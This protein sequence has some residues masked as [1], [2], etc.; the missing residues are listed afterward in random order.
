MNDAALAVALARGPFHR[1]LRAAIEARGLSLQCLQ[2]QLD[3][4]D[5]R[6]GTGTLSYW[7]S[8]QRRPERP[9]SLQAVAALEAILGLPTDALLR[10]LDPR[11]RGEAR[12]VSGIPRPIS[13]LLLDPEPMVTLLHDLRGQAPPL[14]LQVAVDVVTLS[15]SGGIATVDTTC[16]VQAQQPTDRHVVTYSSEPGGD[17]QLLSVDV[18]D[19]CRIGR[20]RRDPAANLIAA[21]LLFDFRLQVGQTHLLRYTVRDAN[22]PPANQYF[23]TVVVPA[24]HVITQVR[25][26]PHRLPLL[27]WRFTRPSE[28]APDATHEEMPVGPHHSVHTNLHQVPAGLVGVGWEWG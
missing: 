19:G 18:G 26:S 5:L 22:P 23:R 25:F 10:L 16:V 27:A 15:D 17:A 20:L 14:R 1:A 28:G 6:V 3:A 13:D 21:E 24:R 9:T 12:P 8:G 11:R 2:Q 7:R 4:Q